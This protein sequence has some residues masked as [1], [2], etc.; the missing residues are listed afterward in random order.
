MIAVYQGDRCAPLKIVLFIRNANK[1]CLID[2]TRLTAC[3]EGRV[4]WIRVNECGYW[5]HWSA[6]QGTPL[7]AKS[8]CSF[9]HVS[10]LV[11]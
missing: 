10:C 11:S 1:G 2:T 7:V 8:S 3:E 5:R 6:V 4:T 9:V